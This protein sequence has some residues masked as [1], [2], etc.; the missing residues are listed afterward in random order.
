[1]WAHLFI[2]KAKTFNTAR[3][4]EPAPRQTQCIWRAQ[5]CVRNEG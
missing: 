1:L 3:F 5:S 4:Q 2:V